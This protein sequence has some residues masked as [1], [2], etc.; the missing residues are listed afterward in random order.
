VRD[1]VQT[2]ALWTFQTDPNPPNNEISNGT[3]M[4]DPK[5]DVVE[6]VNNSFNT[7]APGFRYE[8]Y[9]TWIGLDARFVRNIF[10]GYMNEVGYAGFLIFLA[11]SSSGDPRTTGDYVMGAS[12]RP[13]G[14][15]STE[16]KTTKGPGGAAKGS[17]A[18]TI[19]MSIGGYLELIYEQLLAK[20]EIAHAEMVKQILDD[21][22]AK[23]ISDTEALTELTAVSKLL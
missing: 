9:P 12:P 18:G 5:I 3:V 20:G 21:W 1:Y 11:A 6:Y 13:T 2:N 7:S 15:N 10:Q 16:E 4:L 22:I 17:P 19:T 23:K 8:V 14:F